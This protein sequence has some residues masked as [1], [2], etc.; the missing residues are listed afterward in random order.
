V[1]LS[2]GGTS[3]TSPGKARV[4]PAT[5]IAMVLVASFGVVLLLSFSREVGPESDIGKVPPAASTGAMQADSSGRATAAGRLPRRPSAPNFVGSNSMNTSRFVPEAY[6]AYIAQRESA[7]PR[8][9]AEFFKAESREP[10]WAEAMEAR[11]KQ[12]FDP[13]ILATL[14]IPS[15]RLDEVECRR[16]SCRIEVSWNEAD[17]ETT[18]QHPDV[19]R[20][21]RDPLSYLA[22]RTGQLAHLSSRIRPPFGAEIMPGTYFVRKVP[23]GRYAVTSILLF[24]E[25]D[26]DPDLYA[27]AVE[28]S[29]E[30]RRRLT[31]Q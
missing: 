29:R 13:T 20:F 3:S 11:L 8:H 15:L 17:F 14:Q 4:R 25:K 18:K 23:D 26:I 9:A 12:R 22:G 28:Q 30:E 24:G 7:A 31:G 2:A 19:E 1:R 5:V 27:T 6:S 16:T 10:V 21:G